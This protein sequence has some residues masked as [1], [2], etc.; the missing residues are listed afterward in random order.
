MRVLNRV[1][2]RSKDAT[3]ALKVFSS[4]S[5][6]LAEGRLELAAEPDPRPKISATGAASMGAQ[7]LPGSN[8]HLA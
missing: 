2:R 8:E 4:L 1:S 6:G 5:V 7:V 3:L